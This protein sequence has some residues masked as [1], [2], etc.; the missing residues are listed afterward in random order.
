MGSLRPELVACCFCV[1]VMLYFSLFKGVKS[2]GKVVWV[3]ATA[4][5]IILTILLIRGLFLPGAG[6]SVILNFNLRH[7][8]IDMSTA[9]GDVNLMH[10]CHFVRRILFFSLFFIL[11]DFQSSPHI[12]QMT[13]TGILYYLN[14]QLEKLA[15]PNVWI[16]AAVQVFFSIGVGF[17]VHLTYASF[18]KFHNNC[19]T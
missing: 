2:S 17:G 16:D 6:L 15:E 18:N 10:S 1:F 19:Y 11:T 5:Y 7:F 13:G 12:S 3:T 9:C 14:P 8:L 4:P